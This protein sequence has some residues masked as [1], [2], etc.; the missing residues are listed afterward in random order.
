MVTKQNKKPQKK[1]RNE[2]DLA[3]YS[4]KMSRKVYNQ[5][6][7]KAISKGMKFYEAMEEAAALYANM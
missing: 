4:G 3:A 2:E 5:L 6:R 1:G 7:I